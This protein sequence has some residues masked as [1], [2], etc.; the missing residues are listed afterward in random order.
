METL[1]SSTQKSK[2]SESLRTKTNHN[3]VSAVWQCGEIQP[4]TLCSFEPERYTAIK[5][6]KEIGRMLAKEEREKL[7][8]FRNQLLTNAQIAKE[9]IPHIYSQYPEVAEHAVWEALLIILWMDTRK[10]QTKKV[11]SALWKTP[12]NIER[13]KIIA[14]EWVD[15]RLKKYWKE[16]VYR[17]Q[18]EWFL[19]WLE[20]QWKKAFS[21]E[22]KRFIIQLCKDEKY[23]DK[24]W[25]IKR[26]AIA[27]EVNA[28]FWNWEKVR[29]SAAIADCYRRYGHDNQS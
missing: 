20:L 8:I 9:L 26:S 25:K 23:I 6:V 15:A 17:Q 1:S 2:N 22:E 12:E 29:K 7:I 4:W 18:C 5:K 11:R 16:E 27:D 21:D 19:K 10:E 3:L 28:K 24:F 14:K 13:L